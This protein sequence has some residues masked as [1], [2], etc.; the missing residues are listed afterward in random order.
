[1]RETNCS[2]GQTTS[3]DNLLRTTDGRY[4]VVTRN[5]AAGST[6][7]APETFQVWIGH[8]GNMVSNAVAVAEIYR[9]S[10]TTLRLADGNDGTNNRFLDVAR[11]RNDGPRQ[12][13]LVDGDNVTPLSL[14]TKVQTTDTQTVGIYKFEAEE[15]APAP[16]QS[17]TTPTP[18]TPPQAA[19]VSTPPATVIP[20]PQ[21]A[22]VAPP[23]APAVTPTATTSSATTAD[24][25]EATSPPQPG[26]FQRIINAFTGRRQ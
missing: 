13:R 6:L 25:A 18:T 1:M 2:P 22:V 20:Q 10:G 17:S 19:V 9:G 11:S 24:I 7:N 8:P 3:L 12:T 16:T 23:Q 5:T 26:F 21:A 15:R 14:I 4:V